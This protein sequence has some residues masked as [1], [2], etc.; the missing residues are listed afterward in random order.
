MLQSSFDLVL[1][2]IRFPDYSGIDVIK[3][4]GPGRMPLVVFLTA[5]EE[6][7]VNAFELNA[8]DYVL[9]PFEE[10][11]LIAS[12]ER[13]RARLETTSP[14]AL[15]DQLQRLLNAQDKKQRYLRR[16]AARMHDSYEIIP[17]EIIDWIEAAD[18]YVEL[19][20]GDKSYLVLDTMSSLEQRLDP[21]E[22]V[23]VHRSRIVNTSRITAIAALANGSYEVQLR[24]GTRLTTGRQFRD[25]VLRFVGK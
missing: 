1:L 14:S 2:D 9:K 8:V 6:F 15:V 7:A 10:E 25:A 17:V 18:N 19:H 23:R 20:C 5:Y 16:V 3:Q 22:F 13:A 11:R 12:I 24:N 4:I 21:D